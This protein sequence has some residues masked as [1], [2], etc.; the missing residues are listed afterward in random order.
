M[1]AL[2]LKTGCVYEPA[3]PKSPYRASEK[4]AFELATVTSGGWDASVVKDVVRGAQEMP[5]VAKGLMLLELLIA[6]DKSEATD[7]ETRGWSA[8]NAGLAE[9]I[10]ICSVKDRWKT[11]TSGGWSDTM[12]TFTFVGDPTSHICEV[13]L[14]HTDMLRVRKEMGA[15]KGYAAFRCVANGVVLLF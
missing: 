11:P 6:C 8:V 12:I 14:V 9:T 1:L 15:H 10:S 4:I 2:S 5:D 3:K 7:S 13:Q